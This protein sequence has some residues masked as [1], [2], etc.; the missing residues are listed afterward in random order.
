[1]TNPVIKPNGNKFWH[2]AKGQYHRE[3]GPAI[4]LASGAKFWYIDD[5]LHRE[6][7]PAIENGWSVIDIRV[8]NGN[9]GVF[10]A[11]NKMWYINGKQIK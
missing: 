7:G 3:N 11:S 10:I 6:D 1:M 5:L 2:N 4:E 8:T 9:A